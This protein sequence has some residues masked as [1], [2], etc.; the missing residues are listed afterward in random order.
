MIRSVFFLSLG[1]AP[2]FPLQSYS[3]HLNE[4]PLGKEPSYGKVRQAT[5]PWN[6]DIGIEMATN[7]TEPMGWNFDSDMA[8]SSIREIT[9]FEI[10]TR[11]VRT[12]PEALRGPLKCNMGTR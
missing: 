8:S 7:D 12:P 11:D 3:T 5:W 2:T 6:S 10:Q 4:I 1:K 9:V